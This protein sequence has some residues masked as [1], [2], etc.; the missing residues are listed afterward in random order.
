MTGMLDFAFL[1]LSLRSAW[2]NGHATTYRALLR[3]L[4]RRGHRVRFYERDRSWYADNQDL[5]DDLASCLRLYDGLESLR[6]QHGRD[7]AAADV[8][9]LGSFVPEGARVADWLLRAAHGITAFYDIDTPVTMAMLREGQCDYLRAEQIADFRLYL[10]FTGGPFLEHL[11]CRYG[12]RAEPLYCAVDAQQYAP[13]RASS[14]Y[15]LGYLGTYSVDR[16]PLLQRFLLELAEAWPGGRFAVAGPQYPDAIGWPRNVTRIEHLAPARHRAFYTSQ[17]FTLNLTRADMV[18]AGWSP[19]VRLFE[20]A[21]CG[22]PIISDVWPGIDTFF[23]PGEEILLA[24]EPVQVLEW[25]RN[26]PEPRRRALGAAA[27]RRVLAEHT[28]DHRARTLERYIDRAVP[29]R[30][31]VRSNRS[32]CHDSA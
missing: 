25:L 3:A 26:M 6:E 28:A 31:V 24:R 1:G 8:V 2:G 13:S 29:R 11:C 32:I 27:R 18:A 30:S 10:S 12:A 21:A 19:S 20:A 22:V 7:I 15:D 5:P 14:R 16:Q 9:V 17:R 23:A 4:L